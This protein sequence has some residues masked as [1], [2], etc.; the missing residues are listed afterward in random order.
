MIHRIV[1]SGQMGRMVACLMFGVWSCAGLIAQDHAGPDASASA[2]AVR[3]TH[4]I[5]FEEISNN[6]N[7]EL[8]IQDD[9]LRFAKRG[10][11]CFQIDIGSIQNVFLGV[12][13][14]Q[15]GGTSMAV[16]RAAA[17]FGGGRVVGIFAHKK[18]ETVTLQY[19]DPDG[20]LHGAIFQVDKGQGQVVVNGLEAI[21]VHITRPEIK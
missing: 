6:L 1:A 12:E 18:Y 16:T 5:G 14:K 13:D 3:A 21:G 17:P 11:P 7:G 19:I 2:L 4:I 10:G 15:V 8:S 20:G 9:A